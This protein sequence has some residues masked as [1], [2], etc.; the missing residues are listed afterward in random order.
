[1]SGQRR[2][3]MAW[4]SRDGRTEGQWQDCGPRVGVEVGTADRASVSGPWASVPMAGPRTACQR[5]DCESVSRWQ[6]CGPRA[7]VRSGV[8]H[9]HAA[10]HGVVMPYLKR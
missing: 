1:M 8:P 2:G 9:Q 7:G 6:N 3:P 4:Q 10:V 5:R